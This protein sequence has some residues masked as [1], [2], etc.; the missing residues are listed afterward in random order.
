MM[1]SGGGDLSS[2]VPIWL[3]GGIG[4]SMAF[5]GMK[6]GCPVVKSAEVHAEAMA[7]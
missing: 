1:V 4:L 6:A 2:G 3:L 5:D 7:G